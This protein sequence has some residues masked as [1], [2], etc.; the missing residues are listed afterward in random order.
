LNNVALIDLKIK[1]IAIIE[2]Q[3][4]SVENHPGNFN[5]N[6]NGNLAFKENLEEIISN[7]NN[8]SSEFDIALNGICH[9]INKIDSFVKS[10][11]KNRMNEKSKEEENEIHEYVI[12]TKHDVY[13]SQSNHNNQSK[14]NEKNYCMLYY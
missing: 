5:S 10:V 9:V 3:I 4:S 1:E 13:D 12:E 2:D 14:Q 8:L 7:S 11:E 6:L